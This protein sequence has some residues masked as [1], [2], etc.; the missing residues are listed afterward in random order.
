M[1]P[2]PQFAPYV[3]V[4]AHPDARYSG[5]GLPS[6][7]GIRRARRGWHLPR[8]H[9]PDAPILRGRR[10]TFT[11]RRRDRAAAR[12]A[13]AVRPCSRIARRRTV[14][15]WSPFD[16]SGKVTG[17]SGQLAAG[18]PPAEPFAG[19]WVSPVSLAVS[20]R[21]RHVRSGSL[22]F[23]SASPVPE[24]AGAEEDEAQYL[25]ISHNVSH[26]TCLQGR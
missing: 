13:S 11:A 24:P 16:R 15:Y 8:R 9:V 1:P 10:G 4:A 17:S 19:R 14:G 7:T 22:P 12:P 5:Y 26:D 23:S 6:P 21:V 3:T 18:S 2:S 25:P 20:P